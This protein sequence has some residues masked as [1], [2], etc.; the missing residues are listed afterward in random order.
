MMSG[1]NFSIPRI[2]QVLTTATT[3]RIEPVKDVF[4]SLVILLSTA[5]TK[6]MATQTRSKVTL[7][8]TSFSE[9]D[10]GLKVAHTKPIA[11]P[12]AK[13][14]A[15]PFVVA[16]V[17]FYWYA[18][19]VPS[20]QVE[21]PI[22]IPVFPTA[23]PPPASSQPSCPQ[24]EPFFQPTASPRP[25]PKP[26][27][28]SPVVPPSTDLPQLEAFPDAWDLIVSR[29]P[30]R[31]ELDDPEGAGGCTTLIRLPFL[32]LFIHLIKSND[33]DIKKYAVVGRE[34]DSYPPRRI[35]MEKAIIKSLNG[36]YTLWQEA[37]FFNK[38]DL[39][40]WLCHLGSIWKEYQLFKSSLNNLGATINFAETMLG[41]Y[42]V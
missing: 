32:P 26:A 23:S 14:K 40:T 12:S 42:W 22:I 8:Y 39:V 19:G 29:C 24:P 27:D 10:A 11:T 4:K 25:S 1:L 3:S 31:V 6:I 7:P 33:F 2:L 17:V 9:D 37:A 16:L 34:R 21:Y 18:F 30:S 5:Q 36:V 28:S 13:R 15:A 38:G 41:K 35:P 20:I